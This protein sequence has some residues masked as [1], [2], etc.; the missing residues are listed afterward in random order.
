MAIKKYGPGP[1]IAFRT[2]LDGLPIQEANQTIHASQEAGKSHACGHDGHMAIL[3]DL[4]RKTENSGFDSGQLMLIFQP[5]EETGL[6][7]ARMI[8]HEVFKRNQVDFCYALHNI[9]GLEK[10]VVFSKEGS[11]ACASVG[12]HVELNGKTA[13]AAHPEDAINPI[14]AAME[15]T[16]KIGGLPDS[17]SIEGF[18]LTTPIALLSGDKNFGTSPE[19]AVVMITLRAAS[20]DDLNWMMREAEKIVH[21]IEKS[22]GIK[23][24]ISFHE[25]FP[26]V[27]NSAH[28]LRI[29]EACLQAKVP[30]QSLDVP[31]RWSEDFSQFSNLFPI[32][33]FGLGAGSDCPPLHASNYD[34]PDDLIDVG[35]SVFLE[36]FKQHMK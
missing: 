31:F 7:A 23:A 16:K 33:M 28:I 13:H 11:F 29:D 30:H 22:H 35:S 25:Y 12:L 15:L 32:A 4:L 1:F 9:P 17:T 6:G 21:D 8:K 18:A 10:G 20:T 3:L 27:E 14:Y 34:F 24:N 19:K 5:A 36:L 2:E 26:A